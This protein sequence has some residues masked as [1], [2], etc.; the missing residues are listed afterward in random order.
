MRLKLIFISF[1]CCISIV[2]CKEPEYKKTRA[3]VYNVETYHWGAGYFKLRVY[4]KYNINGV[5]YKD[6]FKYNLG[7][8]YNKKDFG[9]GDSFLIRFQKNKHW[10]TQFVRIT[11][12]KDYIEYL[13]NLKG[14]D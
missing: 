14:V 13:K 8:I 7:R 4:Y 3:F 10:K 1:Y 12:D 11:Y 5:I 6:F 9:Q 2:S